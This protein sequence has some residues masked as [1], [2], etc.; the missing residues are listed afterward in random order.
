MWKIEFL[1]TDNGRCPAIDFIDKLPEKTQAKTF[2]TF[3]IV[4]NSRPVVPEKFFKKLSGTNLYEIR[5]LHNKIKYRYLSFFHDGS[6]I[7]VAHAFLK[8][9]AKTPAKEIAVAI[10]RMK[11]FLEN[12]K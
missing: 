7:V 1:V 6:I 2:A 3:K 4:Q 8:D 12:G 5:V 10:K 9:F 11:S